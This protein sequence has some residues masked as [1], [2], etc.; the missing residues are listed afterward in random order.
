MPFALIVRPFGAVDGLTAATLPLRNAMR[1]HRRAADSVPRPEERRPIEAMGPILEHG[2]RPRG[3]SPKGGALLQRRASPWNT[4]IVRAAVAPKG[5]PIA[6]KGTALEHGYRPRGRSPKGGVLSE[7]RVS[8]WNMDI[9][10]VAVAPKGRAIKAKGIA[11][12]HGYRPRGRS[13]KGA[14]Y[15]SEGHRPGTRASSARRQ[16]Q[17][18]RTNAAQSHT[19]LSS[20]SISCRLNNSRNS[21]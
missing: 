2:H 14:C 19:Y 11:L 4:G 10:H 7:R 1:I 6:A 17:P 21:S 5:R 20:H 8:P 9:A 16:P 18:G 12:E 3:R 13:P 15:H